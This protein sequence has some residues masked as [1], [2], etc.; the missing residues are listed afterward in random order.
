MPLGYRIVLPVAVLRV[1]ARCGLSAVERHPEQV[2]HGGYRLRRLG[3]VDLLGVR[4][5]GAQPAP[6]QDS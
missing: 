4:L 5:N 1:L 2:L 3:V 6:G